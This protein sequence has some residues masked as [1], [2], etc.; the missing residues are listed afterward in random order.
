MKLKLW[1]KGAGI[2]NIVLGILLFLYSRS[3]IIPVLFL[4]STGF[5]Y[6]TYFERD[7]VFNN[8]WSLKVLGIINLFCNFISG[9]IV[10]EISGLIKKEE[11]YSISV[12]KKSNKIN[13]LLQ[14]GVVLILLSGIMIATNQSIIVSDIVKIIGLMLLSG[15]FF[16][17]S[18]MS[19]KYLKIE[20]SFKTYFIL[21]MSFIV[22]SF[23]GLYYYNLLGSISINSYNYLYFYP[24][25]YIL[26]SICLYFVGKVIKN[27]LC[28]YLCVFGV[29]VCLFSW[30]NALGLNSIINLL[31]INVSSCL[32]NFI[33]NPSSYGVKVVRDTSKYIS[34]GLIPINMILSV[35]NPFNYCSVILLLLISTLNVFHLFVKEKNKVLS[36]ISVPTLLINS[37]LVTF[38]SDD[39]LKIEIVIYQ[40]VV[41]LLYNL[42]KFI[43][44]DSINELFNKLIKILFNISIIAT[45]FISLFVDSTAAI[46]VCSLMVLQ[47]IIEIIK[48]EKHEFYMEPF[49]SL[50]LAISALL[51]FNEGRNV[52]FVFNLFLLSIIELALYLLIKKMSVK[53]I[54]YVLYLV[55]VGNIVLNPTDDLFLALITLISSLI[56]LGLNIIKKKDNKVALGFIFAFIVLA[57]A[58]S[59]FINIYYLNYLFVFVGLILYAYIFKN[60]LYKKYYALFASCL[61]LFSFTNIMSLDHIYLQC[62]NLCIYTYLGGIISSLIKD[63]YSK[64]LFI[65]I[66]SIVIILANMFTSEILIGVTICLITLLLIIYSFLKNFKKVKV[67]AIILFILNLIYML[68]DF[69]SDI[70]LAIYLLILGFILIGVVIFKEIKDNK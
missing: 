61:M 37:S 8:K 57:N 43:R 34:L 41:I 23:I 21:G 44:L 28:Y 45:S 3:T 20:S 39:A 60:D 13:I 19:K 70:P 69:W 48:L 66:Y 10:L 38:M 42:I 36:I 7:N 2:F 56:P 52:D 64:D 68:R 35:C 33:Y 14:L 1:L 24:L 30:F 26:I 47:N 22:I 54:H 18:F 65:M 5:Y 16:L 15:I 58:N 67:S 59:V 29:Y 9:I 40:I 46:I 51:I 11:N 32:I 17:L 31:L 62:I 25:L 55:L 4:V 27:N 50:L 12:D 63:N 49:K 6:Q 53:T